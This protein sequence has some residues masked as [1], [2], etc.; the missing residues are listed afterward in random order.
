M[1][2]VYLVITTLIAFFNLSM[3]VIK[4]FRNWILGV[5]KDKKK[6]MEEEERQNETHRC[7]LRD[8]I[9]DIYNRHSEKGEINFFDLENVSYLYSQYKALGGNSFI[10]EIWHQIEQWKKVQ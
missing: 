9:L 2:T 1:E 5:Q 6:K 8:R 3:I 7:L 10:D 4:P